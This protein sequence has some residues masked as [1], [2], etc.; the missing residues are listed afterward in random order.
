VPFIDEVMLK[1]F[2]AKG[3]VPNKKT[4]FSKKPSDEIYP[5]DDSPLLL[6]RNQRLGYEDEVAR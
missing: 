5:S 1:A 4:T 2:R 3:N 6:H